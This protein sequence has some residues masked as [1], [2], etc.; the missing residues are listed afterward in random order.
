MGARCS[1][2]NLIQNVWRS[3]RSYWLK[4]LNNNA[5]I[6]MSSIKADIILFCY[7][8]SY[9]LR[10]PYTLNTQYPFKGCVLLSFELWMRTIVCT[11]AQCVMCRQYYTFGMKHCWMPPLIFLV[12]KDLTISLSLSLMTLYYLGAICNGEY[13]CIVER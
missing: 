10:I 4:M 13:M 12:F 3:I 11:F 2:A 8:C 9:V 1:F 7:K 6:Y 5:K